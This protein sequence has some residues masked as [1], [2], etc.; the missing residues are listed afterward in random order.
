MVEMVQSGRFAWIG[1]GRH[2]TS[3]THVDNVIEGLLLGPR[4][5][6]RGNAYFVTDGEPVVFREFVGELLATQGV[7]PPTRNI[8]AAVARPLARGGESRLAAPS[9]TR[10]PAA[11]AAGLLALGAGV[12]DQDRQGARAAR[13]PAGA[14]RSPDG[15]AELQG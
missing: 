8:P 6:R 5:G 9:A 14:G 15:L 13:L 2:L 10:P 7:T 4:S 12:H 11:D 3:T 1:G